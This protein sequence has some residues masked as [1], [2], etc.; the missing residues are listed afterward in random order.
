MG[1]Y[2]HTHT[3]IHTHGLLKNKK[4]R[5]RGITLIALVVTIV[6]LIILAVISINV[7][8]SENGIIKKAEQAK[9]MH[10]SSVKTEKEGMNKLIEQYENMTPASIPEGLEVGTKVTYSPSGTY[11]WQA[12]YYSTD[13]EKTTDD[14]ILSSASGQDFAISKWKVLNIDKSTGKIELVPE[15]PTTG[16]VS[17]IGAQGYNNGVKLL[18]EACSSL[19]GDTKNKIEARSINIGDIE[20]YMTEKS[21][22]EVHSSAL[23]GVPYG[24]QEESAYSLDC[25][26]YPVIYGQENLATINGNTNEKGLKLS[27][28]NR[29]IER[30]EGTSISDNIGEITTATSIQPYQ[31]KWEKV[32]SFM[33]TAFKD[34]YYNLLI[35]KGSNNKCWIASRCVKTC[36]YYCEFHMQ[37][38]YN[39]NITSYTICSS[40]P[41]KGNYSRELF[42]VV[43]LSCK[44]LQGNAT[45]GFIV[46]I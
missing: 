3:H 36:N 19:Y 5:E 15:S 17:L 44:L 4:V 42:P 25:S 11:N 32:N 38:M 39:G 2:T 40:K 21:L 22:A 1:L 29:F 28:Q 33:Q 46:S 13:L 41:A 6:V 20:K 34:N 24:K 7:V 10:E 35:P 27:E 23:Y 26:K 18:N 12:E 45:S 43:T 37:I 31:T 30:S 14:V 8:F 16:T 9:D